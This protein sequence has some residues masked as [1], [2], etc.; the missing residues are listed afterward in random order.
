MT[1]APL[2]VAKDKPAELDAPLAGVRWIDL[3]GCCTGVPNHRHALFAVAGGLFYAA[4]GAPVLAVA[5]ATVVAASDH[6]PDQVPGAPKPVP[7][8]RADGNF[9]MLDLG[10]GRYTNYAHL[11]PGSIAVAP[12]DRVKAGQRLG[13][14]GN[15]GQTETPHLHFLVMENEL[16][17]EL[18]VLDFPERGC[19]SAPCQAAG[20]RACGWRPK[21]GGGNDRPPGPAYDRGMGVAHSKEPD[22]D[23]ARGIAED[24]CILR[25]VVGSTVHGLSNPGTDDRDEMGVCIEPKDYVIGLR[26]FEHWTSRTQPDGAPS[27]PGDLD[28][29]VYGLRKYCRLAVKGSPTA[30]LLLFIGDEHVLLRDELGGELQ[31]LAP[32]F[33]SKRTGQAFLG[34]F[35]SQRRGLVGDRHATRTRE[36]SAEHGYDTKY[37]MHALRI[38]VQGLEL[39]RDGRI[40]LPVPEPDRSALLAVRRGE[41]SLAEV[42]ARLDDAGE[43][44]RAAVDT[45]D[46]PDEA[47]AARID[48]FLVSAYER[49][50]ATRA[51]T[52]G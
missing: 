14:V 11:E 48:A 42:L 22:R 24:G 45:N 2:P 39:I 27:G 15:S 31:A 23:L 52:S 28:L 20:S 51:T 35:D 40:T 36:L 3:T 10:G 50:W 12:G 32:A 1:A 33:L 47:D 18:T 29:V 49:V 7:A 38:S 5:D 44:L 17:L 6:L 4:Y 41:P 46:L 21:I 43:R 26:A 16:P 19:G 30:L 37:A 9:V 34:Y 13:L 25:C 8:E